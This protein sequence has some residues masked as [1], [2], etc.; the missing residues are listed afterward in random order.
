MLQAAGLFVSLTVSWMLLTQHFSGLGLAIAASASVVCVVM[1]MRMPGLGRGTFTT[2]PRLAT[3]LA[4]RMAGAFLGA[5]RVIGAAISADI[6]LDPA[7]VRIR[8]GLT[9]ELGR[10]MFADVLGASPGI[11]VIGVDDAGLLAHVN[12][13]NGEELRDVRDWE[14][15]IG[16][17]VGE[18]V[19]P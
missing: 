6:R 11:V 2:A 7:L 19:R 16:A 4:S 17:A 1:A 9:G 8:T 10:A 5:L 18:R 13:E 12:E 15:R 3:V 14:A